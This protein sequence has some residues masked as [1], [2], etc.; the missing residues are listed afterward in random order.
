MTNSYSQGSISLG[1]AG[2][3]DRLWLDKNGKVGIGTTAPTGLLDIVSATTAA[4][5]TISNSSLSFLDTGVSGATT[6]AFDTNADFAWRTKT[7]ANRGGN[8]YAANLMILTATGKLGIG[9][10]NPASILDISSHGGRLRIIQNTGGNIFNGIDFVSY[11]NI[12]DSFSTKTGMKTF[13]KSIF[14]INYY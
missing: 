13:C 11:N 3:L 12:Y 5:H 7:Y 8:T 6:A 10:T 14:I 1:S 2:V 9:T 4:Y